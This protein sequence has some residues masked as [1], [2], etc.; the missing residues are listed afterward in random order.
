MVE[1]VGF[2]LVIQ[3]FPKPFVF[4]VNKQTGDDE[5]CNRHDNSCGSLDIA[6]E[7]AA[8]LKIK[9]IELKLVHSETLSK[10]L[11]IS[12]EKKV[13]MTQGGLDHPSLIVPSTFSSSPLIMISVS[14]ASLSL[15]AVDALIHLSSLNDLM[16]VRVSS[17]DF[18]V[19]NGVIKKAEAQKQ[20]AEEQAQDSTSASPVPSRC[21]SPRTLHINKGILFTYDQIR[22]IF[23]SELRDWWLKQRSIYVACRNDQTC[24]LGTLESRLLSDKPDRCRDP[25]RREDEAIR[26]CVLLDKWT[27][28]PRQ[29]KGCPAREAISHAMDDSCDHC[30]SPADLEMSLKETGHAEGR[31]DRHFRRHHSSNHQRRSFWST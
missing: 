23:S 30:C 31:K 16:L 24:E 15:T 12:D 14:N 11:S 17:G 10:T 27:K 2:S 6:F 25:S 22:T 8:K 20:R 21:A 1:T 4:E 29:F 13:F 28:E 5:S 18:K 26:C 7:T 9:S 3:P 19:T